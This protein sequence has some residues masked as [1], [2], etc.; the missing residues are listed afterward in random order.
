ML[1]VQGKNDRN[2][3]RGRGGVSRARLAHAQPTGSTLLALMSPIPPP[4][5]SHYLGW[6]LLK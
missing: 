5:D 2:E 6:Y 4:L 3:M 1:S